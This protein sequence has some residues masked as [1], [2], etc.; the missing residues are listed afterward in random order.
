MLQ[1]GGSIHTVLGVGTQGHEP[2]P[3]GDGVP[4]PSS[5]WE[6]GHAAPSLN[7]VSGPGGWGP[8]C[9]RGTGRGAAWP[10]PYFEYS[11]WGWGPR[12]F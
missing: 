7:F 2:A 3:Q 9:L 5:D 11:A 6:A 4:G 10:L 1:Q 12:A 8:Q